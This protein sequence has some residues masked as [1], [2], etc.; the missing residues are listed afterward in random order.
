MSQ[1]VALTIASKDLRYFLFFFSQKEWVPCS[2][3]GEYFNVTK[4]HLQ[5]HMHQERL[6]A[7]LC[8]KWFMDYLHLQIVQAMLQVTI[9]L[10]VIFSCN[11]CELNLCNRTCSFV[12]TTLFLL[13]LHLYEFVASR[14]ISMFSL[15]FFLF[16]IDSG[17]SI[18]ALVC[19][20]IRCIGTRIEWENESA[21]L[22]SWMLGK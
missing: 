19:R 14:L 13:S 17:C 18:G 4:A 5:F 12:Q 20:R 21:K 7:C 10:T 9:L 3:L 8:E 2:A 15:L 1:L 6:Y 11:P 16:E 22:P